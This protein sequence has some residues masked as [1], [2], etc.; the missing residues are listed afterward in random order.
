MTMSRRDFLFRVTATLGVAAANGGCSSAAPFGRRGIAS[1]Q[2]PSIGVQLY[3]VRGLMQQDAARTIAAVAAAGF[4]EVEFAGF[5]G[6]TAAEMRALID[7]NALRSPAGHVSI[8]DLRANLPSLLADARTMG[9]LWLI[10]PWID[11]RERT[12]E[13]YHSLARDLNHAGSIA[14]QSGIRVAYHAEDYDF[15]P[16]Q[17]GLVPY[18]LLLRETDP[19]RVDMELD[20]YWVAKGGGNA[21]NYLERFPGRFP[22]LH[23]K[24]ITADGRMANAGQGVIDFPTILSAARRSGTTH[25]IIENDEPV[26]PLTDIASGLAYLKRILR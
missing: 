15:R 9:W 14:G 13:G 3:S 16:L 18:D 20:L 24:D 10:V 6:R 1:I 2:S 4:E 8:D 7:R 26:D 12:M 11:Q 5:Y 22:L 19:A 25:F 17:G 23:I 21:L